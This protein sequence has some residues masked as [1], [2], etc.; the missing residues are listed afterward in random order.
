MS[1]EREKTYSLLANGTAGPKFHSNGPM[2]VQAVGTWGGGTVSVQMN[3]GSGATE[4]Y[5]L[6]AADPVRVFDFP[7]NAVITFVLSG[8]T[9]PDL[10]IEVR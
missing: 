4:V 7:P 6:T 1:V 10:K 2:T 8:A 5:A 3:L 9:A